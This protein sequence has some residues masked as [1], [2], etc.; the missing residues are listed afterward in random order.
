MKFTYLYS[1]KGYVYGN[2][3]GGGRA[4]YPSKKLTG[5]S[6]DEIRVKAEAMLKD[7]SLDSGM[8]YESLVGAVLEVTV[9]KGVTIKGEIFASESYEWLIVGKLTEDVVDHLTSLI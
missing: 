1:A 2:L 4:A 9:I 6:I 7:G 5:A 3:W 8:G